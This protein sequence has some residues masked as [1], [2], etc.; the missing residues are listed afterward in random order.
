V[1]LK[2]FPLLE[3][4]RSGEV[5][6]DHKVSFTFV[7]CGGHCFLDR[8]TV[9][10]DL[11]ADTFSK[12]RGFDKNKHSQPVLFFLPPNPL[13]KVLVQYPSL[14]GISETTNVASAS[15]SANASKG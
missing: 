3:T 13:I 7:V 14:P 1:Y 4:E 2:I 9:L 15:A 5:D 11:T 10:L 8:A 6:S 12:S